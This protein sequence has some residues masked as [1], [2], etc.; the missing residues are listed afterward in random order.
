MKNA[1]A[2][3][4]GRRLNME[5]KR[6]LEKLLL[7]DIDMAA[8]KFSAQRAKT[9]S[10]AEAAAIKNA[11][12]EAKRLI[13]HIRR[14]DKARQTAVNALEQLGYATDRY[15]R[16]YE[17]AIH[18]GTKPKALRDFDQETENGS[19]S[20]LLSSAPTPS[21]SSPAARR[22]SSSLPRSAGS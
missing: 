21:S 16:K 4:T 22:H 1:N 18:Y 14:S 9:R 2:L 15:G 13:E 5:E 3:P 19:G 6:K 12:R 7:A 11:P 17:L 10:S 20:S 8:A